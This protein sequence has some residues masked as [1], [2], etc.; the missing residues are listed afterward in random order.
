MVLPA[1]AGFLAAALVTGLLLG[2]GVLRLGGAGSSEGQGPGFET[3]EEAAMAFV[4]GLREGDID[5]MAGVFAIESFAESCDNAALLEFTRA[6]SPVGGLCPYP[7]TT[8]LGAAANLEARRV[9]VRSTV[10]QTVTI[11]TSPQLWNDGTPEMLTD[12]QAIDDFIQQTASDFENYP[13][14][15][16]ENATSVEPGTLYDEYDSV[17]ELNESAAAMAGLAPDDY[18]DVAITFEI[19]GETWL[20]APSA[21]RYDGRWYLTHQGGR[22]AEL[23]GMERIQGG[24]GRTSE[25]DLT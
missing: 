10:V 9:D 17:A 5:A 11:H 2:T 14:A 7:A 22:L 24:L 8:D 6:Y 23:V 12:E 18:V 13:F 21:G 20:F 1:L 3:P 19:D 25:L 15:N 4:E 16:L